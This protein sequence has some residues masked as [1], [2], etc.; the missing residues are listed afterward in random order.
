M[1]EPPGRKATS[2]VTHSA[3]HLRCGSLCLS[4]H[5]SSGK[6]PATSSGPESAAVFC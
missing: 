5:P 6:E 4:S 1:A 2:K 3:H